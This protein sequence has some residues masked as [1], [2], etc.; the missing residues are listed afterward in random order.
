MKTV[1]LVLPC[2]NEEL[3]INDSTVK[4]KELMDDLI[5]KETV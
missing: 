2:Y 5:D 1:Y 3:V 4:L